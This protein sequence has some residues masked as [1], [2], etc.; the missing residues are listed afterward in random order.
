MGANLKKMK[1]LLKYT[2]NFILSIV[3]FFTLNCVILVIAI[4][5][6]AYFI[7]FSSILKGSYQLFLY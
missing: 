5:Y 2:L 1:T 4:N 7:V 3:V 6:E